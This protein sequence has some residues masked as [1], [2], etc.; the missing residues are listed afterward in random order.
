VYSQDMT[1]L[2]ISL[3]QRFMGKRCVFSRKFKFRF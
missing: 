3:W 1:V 2:A